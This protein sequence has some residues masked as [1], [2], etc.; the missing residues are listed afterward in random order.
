MEEFPDVDDNVVGGG[1]CGG[2]PGQGGDFGGLDADNGAEELR[3]DMQRIML[4]EAASAAQ[5][6][7]DP[8]DRPPA[9]VPSFT[10]SPNPI[11]L[12]QK[13]SV[14][15]PASEDANIM[16]HTMMWLNSISSL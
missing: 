11:S 15:R 2:M 9:R 8:Q 4:Q 1:T 10:I 14:G 3:V 5:A 12:R 13:T 6:A 7:A 16:A